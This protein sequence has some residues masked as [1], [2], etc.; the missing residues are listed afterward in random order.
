MVIPAV[1]I[2]LQPDYLSQFPRVDHIL[3]YLGDPKGDPLVIMGLLSLAGIFTI[4]NIFLFFQILYQGTFVF[5][6]QREVAA[7][8]FRNYLSKPYSFHLQ[9]NSSV[10]IRN[11]TTEINSFCQYV[12]MPILN[13]TS[14]VLV[15]LALLILL[16][17]VEPIP[18]LC[19]GLCLIGIASIFYRFT[20]SKVARWG[21]ARQVADEE[22]IKCLQQGFGGIKQIML[23]QNLDYFL[24]IFQ[25]PN[26]VSGLMT[27]KEYI[28]QYLPKQ[29]I[30]ILAISGLVGV[31]LFMVFQER[32][33][34]EVM[35]MLSLLATAGFRLIPSF[36]RILK[37]L[38]SIR[39]GWA[40]VDVLTEEFGEVE[41]RDKISS[42]IEK[43][44]PASF[45]DN[46]SLKNIAFS[47]G[48]NNEELLSDLN[49]EAKRGECIGIVGESGVGKS[50]LTNLLLGLVSPSSGIMEVDGCRIKAEN[51][52]SWQQMI[53]Y[54][55]QEIYL[56][57]DTIKH[58]IAFGIN[59]AV[60][61][62]SQVREVVEKAGIQKFI[63]S[64]DEGLNT[65][66]GERG[67][68]LSGGQRQRIGIARALYQNP[69]VLILDESTSA[70][71]EKTEE[72]IIEELRLMKGKVT[73]IIVAH[74]QSTL[75]FCDRI[76][77]MESGRLELLG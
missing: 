30:E 13:L 10:L 9:T 4:K 60:I 23:G 11:L 12:L 27:K 31:C 41:N 70:L 61:D 7:N 24:R 53:G 68:R 64:L 56:L 16:L 47:Y 37:N 14:E 34:L 58:N 77:K 36:S 72:G 21:K 74:R 50:T 42:K 45:T 19:L 73:M 43:I 39:F 32:S 15:V 55:P 76:Y 40:S 59:E 75:Q 33:G 8:L 52:R 46:F 22:K 63:S 26:I 1:G 25:R 6:A 62:H 71:D 65:K 67:V 2:L 17:F 28:F 51:I 48:L 49:F 44:E 69:Q 20:N 38:Q 18:T 54:V 57:D 66:I 3:S 29:F 5:S 35:A